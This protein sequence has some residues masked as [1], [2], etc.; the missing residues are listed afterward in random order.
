MDDF[1]ILITK[2]RQA[3]RDRESNDIKL[4][5]N[6]NDNDE[7]PCTIELDYATGAGKFE[8]NNT[9]NSDEKNMEKLISLTT[10][11]QR[12]NKSVNTSE[13][14]RNGVER[15][16]TFST[17]PENAGRLHPVL[18]KLGAKSPKKRRNMFSKTDVLDL[19][20]T[21]PIYIRNAIYCVVI[22]EEFM[23]ELAAVSIEQTL[24]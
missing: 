11:K 23:K 22:L 4:N 10:G 9:F 20:K 21:N 18:P 8:R 17:P 13:I 24:L 2:A 3:L 7:Q 12:T 16:S 5:N 19:R 14:T 15:S 6:N 1:K